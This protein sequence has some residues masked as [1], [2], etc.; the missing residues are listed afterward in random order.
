RVTQRPLSDY[1]QGLFP[2][3]IIYFVITTQFEESAVV[4]IQYG[5]RKWRRE[6]MERTEHMRRI[7]SSD[8]A[9]K[10]SLG[11]SH[12][13]SQLNQLK[14]EREKQEELYEEIVRTPARYVNAL[15]RVEQQRERKGEER[16][17]IIDHEEI[18]RRN[19]AAR[20]ITRNLRKY[21]IRRS[22]EKRGETKLTLKRRLELIKIL[23]E[24]LSRNVDMRRKSLQEIERRRGDRHRVVRELI[25]QGAVRDR[26]MDI[27][28]RE[29]TMLSA[30]PPPGQS[31]KEVVDMLK[32]MRN[33]LRESIA[34][35][36]HDK[37]MAKIQDI[38][39]GL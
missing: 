3:V 36:S 23:D 25:T 32:T 5:W 34:K 35:R 30:L 2:Y 26:K 21:C 9:G 28:R 37:E 38:L 16:K 7:L 18:T 13:I 6:R 22:I 1:G 4:L 20:V 10:I 11:N 17:R 33:P 24:R 31:T 27:Y 14:A 29:I 15:L 19:Q 12:L 39:L 8:F